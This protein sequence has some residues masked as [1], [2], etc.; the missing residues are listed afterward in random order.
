VEVKVAPVEADLESVMKVD[1]VAIA[2]HEQAAPHRRID[3]AQQNVELVDLKGFL[4]IGHSGPSV[5]AHN[6]V[7]QHPFFPTLHIVGIFD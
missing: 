4:L 1:N 5:S 6:R 3:T 7:Y 2:A